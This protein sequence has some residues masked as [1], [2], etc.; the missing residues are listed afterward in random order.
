MAD[1]TRKCYF[2]WIMIIIGLE[3][4]AFKGKCKCIPSIGQSTSFSRCSKF[5]IYLVK[6]KKIFWYYFNGGC[7]KKEEQ[8]SGFKLIVKDKIQFSNFLIRSLVIIVKKIRKLAVVSR[9]PYT[10]FLNVYY[11]QS[12]RRIKEFSS[13]PINFPY[14]I[15]FRNVSI[16]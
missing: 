10:N 16:D 15:T 13:Y 9:I 2:A 8:I 7:R 11:K 6:M 1:D 3:I 4:C 14:P 5:S 12:G